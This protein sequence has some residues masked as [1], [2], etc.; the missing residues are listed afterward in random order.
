MRNVDEYIAV[1]K[2][3]VKRIIIEKLIIFSIFLALDKNSEI[4][5]CNPIPAIN[6][7]KGIRKS[8]CLVVEKVIF[9]DRTKRKNIKKFIKIIDK[10]SDDIW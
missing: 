5:H 2:E 10:I 1:E 3:K 6:V 4:K 7:M 9:F 8:E